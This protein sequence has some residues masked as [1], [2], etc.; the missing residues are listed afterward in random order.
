MVSPCPGL[1]PAQ[2]PPARLEPVQEI[3]QPCQVK[4][5][6]FLFSVTKICARATGL[7]SGRTA[8]LCALSTLMVDNLHGTCRREL[9]LQWMEYGNYDP[10]PSQPMRFVNDDNRNTQLYLQDLRTIW[11]TTFAVHGGRNVEAR[12]CQNPRSGKLPLWIICRLGFC[13]HRSG[14]LAAR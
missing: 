10:R 14:S 7:L 8:R 9:W 4:P 12:G 6:D 2:P 5:T 13:R 3:E 11:V 1:Y